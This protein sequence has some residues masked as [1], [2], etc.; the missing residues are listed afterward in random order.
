MP[1]KLRTHSFPPCSFAPLLLCS[2]AP[3]SLLLC[4]LGFAGKVVQQAPFLCSQTFLHNKLP[5]PRGTSRAG[6]GSV[7][8]RNFTGNSSARLGTT[9]H[10]LP[11]GEASYVGFMTPGSVVRTPPVGAIPRTRLGSESSR[12]SCRPGMA[13]MLDRQHALGLISTVLTTL[14][15]TPHIRCTLNSR[16]CSCLQRPLVI[17]PANETACAE[18]TPG[19]RRN[20]FRCCFAAG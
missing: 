12:P 19:P 3:C 15:R 9:G 1:K 6:T 10:E 17:E 4:S 20:Q 14:V 7:P 8:A 2:F 11:R 13:V 16:S 18:A 5:P